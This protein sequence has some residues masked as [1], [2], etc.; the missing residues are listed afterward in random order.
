MTQL[1]CLGI[2]HHTASVELR[3]YLSGPVLQHQHDSALRA[4]AVLATCNRVELYAEVDAEHDAQ[5]LMVHFL[6]RVHHTHPATFLNHTYFLSGDEVTNHLCRVAAGLDSQIL[7]EPQILGQVTAAYEQAL[8]AQTGGPLLTRLFQAA[9]RAGKRARSETPISTNPAS[10]SSVAV[11]LAQKVTGNLQQQRVLVIGLGEMG[12]LAIKALRARG[13]TQLN[14]VNRTASKATNRAAAWG[15]QGFSLAELPVALAEADL[16]FSATSAGQPLITP[17]LLADVMVLR[18]HAPLALIDLAVPRDIAPAVATLPGVRRFDMDD[19]RANLDDALKLRQ[20]AVPRVEAIIAEEV[21]EWQQQVQALAVKPHIVA[22]RQK[23]E[24]I[25]QR[26]LARSL[27]FLGDVDPQTRDQLEHLTQSLV[28][29]L[30]HEPT[31]NLKALAAEPDVDDI[32]VT[33]RT[34][35]KLDEQC[36]LSDPV[37]ARSSEVEHR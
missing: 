14:L 16:V 9:I 15:G 22:L 2:S 36:G 1:V 3:E 20:Q 30:L 18:N 29:S 24:H 27:R 21:A 5:E 12:E 7:G 10:I 33:F 11:A 19:L 25:R 28:N 4:L 35:F 6:S 13:V 32:V 17:A 26:E 34:L 8:A 23:A 37:H 31:V